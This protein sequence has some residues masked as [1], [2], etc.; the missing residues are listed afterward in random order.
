MGIVFTRC[1][2][3]DRKTS[4]D[5]SLPPHCT[6]VVRFERNGKYYVLLKKQ[7]FTEI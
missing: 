5:N 6:P 7:S 3:C 1:K 4:I 2:G